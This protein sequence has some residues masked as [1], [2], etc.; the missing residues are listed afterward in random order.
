MIKKNQCVL[1]G[2]MLLS[3]CSAIPL[4]PGAEG[5]RIVT[6][7]QIGCDLQLGCS[8]LGEV[9]GD[10]GNSWAGAWTSDAERE[11]D[12]RNALK[13]AAA[14]LGADTV[15]VL[16]SRAGGAE[17]AGMTNTGIAYRCKKK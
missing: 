15:Q 4:D 9:G 7:D 12:A 11:T 14:K 5:V 8:Y 17:Q 2:V 13:N 6:T 16:R 1:L 3:A 10:Q